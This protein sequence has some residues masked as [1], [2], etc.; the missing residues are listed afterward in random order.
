MC[1]GCIGEHQARRRGHS[2]AAQLCLVCAWRRKIGRGSAPPA[3]H[4]TQPH[5]RGEQPP[6]AAAPLAGWQA[7]TTDLA[8]RP[9][10]RRV[11]T[12]VRRSTL[13]RRLHPSPSP[14]TFRLSPLFLCLFSVFC[15]ASLSFSWSYVDYQTIS[16]APPTTY[17]SPP[18]PPSSPRP[19]GS[20]RR[21]SAHHEPAH[22]RRSASIPPT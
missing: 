10:F 19:I 9:F 14:F 20:S 1:I 17:P 21:H 12:A 4:S 2:Y 16:P 6:P 5:G 7:Q 13:A 18:T 3:N 8:P 22:Q 11:L 15:P